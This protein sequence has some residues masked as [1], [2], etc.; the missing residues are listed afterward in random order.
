MLVQLGSYFILFHTLWIHKHYEESLK[1]QKANSPSSPVPSQT[2]Q[3][4]NVYLT[5]HT[6]F[7]T[8]Y[9]NTS[10]LPLRPC[11]SCIW[12][13]VKTLG[14]Q[15]QNGL[16][17]KERVNLLVLTALREE[18]NE[19][20]KFLSTSP[21]VTANCRDR[22]GTWTWMSQILWQMVLVYVVF[23]S[24]EHSTKIKTKDR[25]T[26]YR[27]VSQWH[28]IWLFAPISLWS[29]PFWLLSHFFAYIA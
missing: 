18:T 25:Q 11:H 26:F 29:T 16:T 2:L 4:I 8:T 24:L 14:S 23:K 20:M 28:L 19:S 10:S 7:N 15:L 12:S 21:S 17:V 22:A 6:I 5:S 27:L 9:C 1:S 3:N 13:I